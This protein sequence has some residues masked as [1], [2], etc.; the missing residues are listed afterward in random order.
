M[1]NASSDLDIEALET[2][3]QEVI[4]DQLAAN[5]SM[6]NYFN[7]YTFLMLPLYALVSFLVFGKP[8]NYG[9][10]LVINCYLQG[11][12]FILGVVFFLLSL[13]INPIV[14]SISILFSIVY[15]QYSYT[16]LNDY[17]AKQSILKLLKFFALLFAIPI[18]IFGLGVLYGSLT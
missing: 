1:A 15:Y 3:R 18:L 4:D 6:L 5:K 7:I 12:A 2:M 10:H 9:E 16:K 8:H 17:S 11:V 14:Y 13:V